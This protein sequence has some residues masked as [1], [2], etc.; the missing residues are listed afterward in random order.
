[1]TI[2][3]LNGGLGNQMFQYALGRKL[4][5]INHVSLKLD[6]SEFKTYTLRTYRLNFFNIHAEIATEDEVVSFKPGEKGVSGFLSSI[7]E[8]LKPYYKRRY[9]KEQFLHYDPNI[10]KCRGDSYL[11]GYWQSEKYFNDIAQIIREDLTLRE[12]SD[13]MNERMAEKISSCD[14][15]SL[16]VRRGDYITNPVTN[17]YHGNCTLDYY[18][19][20]ID[21]MIKNIVDPHFFIFTDDPEWAKKNINTGFPT[22][23]IDHNGP[24]KDYED[25]KLM[26]L[27]K[28]H[29]IANSS[30]SWWGAWLCRN[31]DKIVIAPSKWFNKKEIENETKDLFSESWQR[32]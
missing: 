18:Q 5:Y 30:F 7:P 17:L 32:M 21:E 28:H 31:P 11:D 1:M 6:L 14:A 15:I 24:D 29:I 13:P 20:A 23:V 10:S 19:K 9:I 3:K 2:V 26:S 25:I 16:H 12:R 22:K 4:S 27:C 8:L